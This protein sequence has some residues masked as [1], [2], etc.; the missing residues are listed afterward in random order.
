MGVAAR[1]VAL[2]GGLGLCGCSERAEPQPAATPQAAAGAARAASAPA[3][4]APAA[5]R[6]GVTV[7]ARIH[8][9]LPEMAFTLVAEPPADGGAALNVRAIQIRRDGAAGVAQ[10]IEGLS[11]A[12]PSSAESPGL[13][14]LDLNF[15]GY[16]DIRLIES[17]PAGPNVPYRHWLYEPATGQFVAAAALDAL[18]APQPDAARR[19]LR[20]DW[21]DGATRSGSDFYV[22]QAGKPGSA[23]VP[24][25]KESR[26][27]TSP[28]A[29]TLSVSVPEDDRWRVVSQK[30]MREP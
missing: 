30:K 26:Q 2:A 27:F 15:D 5:A 14:V 9:D 20:V 25:R 29:F 23:L 17:Q 21:R 1:I 12:T 18:G 28:G 10:R 4:V 3:T 22:W 7:R 19:E 16:A 13:E 6:A 24:V 8:A 11:T